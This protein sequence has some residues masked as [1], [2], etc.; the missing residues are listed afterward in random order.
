MV[1][2]GNISHEYYVLVSYTSRQRLLF[3]VGGGRIGQEIRIK[4]TTSSAFLELPRDVG[5]CKVLET[6]LDPGVCC[7][8]DDVTN[9]FRDHGTV[10]VCKSQIV[11]VF[12][13]TSE[14]IEN[15]QLILQNCRYRRLRT[16]HARVLES[17][18]A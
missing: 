4:K 7:S 5:G 9:E 13:N 17:I 15:V 2:L 6:G 16:S 10:R 8:E 1:L 12:F 11:E 14:N 18:A 3:D